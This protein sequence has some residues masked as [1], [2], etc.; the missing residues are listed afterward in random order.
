MVH[1]SASTVQTGCFGRAAKPKKTRRSGTTSSCPNLA[2]VRTLPRH[3]VLNFLRESALCLTFGV[4]HAWRGFKRAMRAAE[5]R[6][7]THSKIAQTACGPIQ[8]SDIGQGPVILMVHGAGGGFD[9]GHEVG[10]TLVNH[11]FRTIS[12]SRFGYLGTPMPAD[13]SPAAQADAYAALLAFLDIPQATI[14]AASAGTPSALQCAIRHPSRVKSLVLMSP[15]TYVPRANNAPS[16]TISNLTRGVLSAAVVSDFMFW[17]ST[18][19]AQPLLIKS[20]LATSPE[21]L[22]AV[23][24]SERERASHVLDM[25]LPI[26]ARRAGLL[27][28]VGIV[29]SLTRFEL[30]KITAPT[31]IFSAADDAFGTYDAAQYTAKEIPGA[32]FVGFKDGG[33]LA[34]GHEKEV[35]AEILSF[36]K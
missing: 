22:E 31:L 14:V 7:A 17:A 27:H 10:V 16:L 11:G 4:G 24:Q 20:L 15:A 18:R 26:T 29:T 25:V 32:R 35:L 36:M 33:H 6:L 12:I 3:R 21:M 13:A 23:D 30:E 19:L 8:Y 1:V 28:D 2:A 34:V 5:E 9:Q